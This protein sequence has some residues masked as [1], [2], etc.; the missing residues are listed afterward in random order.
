[1]NTLSLLKEQHKKEL[2]ATKLQEDVNR[3]L[4]DLR[5]LIF[6]EGK[7]EIKE[8]DKELER[9]N[10][11][12]VDFVLSQKILGNDGKYRSV[13]KIGS[14]VTVTQ[15]HAEYRQLENGGRIFSNA[16]GIEEK[17]IYFKVYFGRIYSM[18][19]SLVRQLKF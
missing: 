5:D 7:H 10:E 1:M 12:N 11:I 9:L 2:P 17:P 4:E 19:G 18:L 3:L 8:L 14:H 15:P 13:K 16:T 6:E